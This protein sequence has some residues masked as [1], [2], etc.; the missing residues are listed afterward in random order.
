MQNEQ[1]QKA[2]KSIAHMVTEYVDGGIKGGTDWRYGLGSII[3]RRLRRLVRAEQ[4]EP[5]QAVGNNAELARKLRH[6]VSLNDPRNGGPYQGIAATACMEAMTE[7]AAALAKP[8]P[9]E[10]NQ[11]AAIANLVVAAREFWDI[12]NDLS[13]ES[14][15]LDKALEAF[16]S[17]PYENEPEEPSAARELLNLLAKERE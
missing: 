17:I 5:Q 4:G 11:S 10:P 3:E 13:A 15:A 16:S 12:H 14:K 1:I 6:L 7:A 8:L 9:Q 2:A